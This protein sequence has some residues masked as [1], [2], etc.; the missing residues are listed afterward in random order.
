MAVRAAFNH[1]L[2]APLNAALQAR[3]RTCRTS[4]HAHTLPSRPQTHILVSS[5]TCSPP[6][7]PPHQSGASP[8]VLARSVVSGVAFGTFPVPLLPPLLGAGFA[9]AAK[10]NVALAATV[11]LC[12][13]AGAPRCTALRV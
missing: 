8:T 1:F 7:A 3:P 10:L 11:Q 6:C 2:V 12:V 5:L 4:A 9:K 13:G